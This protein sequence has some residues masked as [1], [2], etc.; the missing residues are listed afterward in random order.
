MTN[1]RKKK[2]LAECEF[3]FALSG[4]KGGQNVNK[5]NTKVFLRFNVEYSQVLSED[6]KESLKKT[7]KLT[8]EMELVMS[9]EEY[10]S[11]LKNKEDVSNKFILRIE[12][13]LKKEKRRKKTNVPN[14]AKRKRVDE[15]K[16][17]SETKKN[18]KWSY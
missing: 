5:V 15:K 18:R 13:N 8:K 1:P 7:L 17:R 10:R 2:I 3:S 16:K 9:S 4:G 14:S 12:N 11:Q 6:E